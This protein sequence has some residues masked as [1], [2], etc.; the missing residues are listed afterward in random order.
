MRFGSSFSDVRALRQQLQQPAL[1]QQL[2]DDDV[3]AVLQ[4][5]ATCTFLLHNDNSDSAACIR[6]SSFLLSFLFS[7][8]SLPYFR[9]LVTLLL[10]LPL[11]LLPRLL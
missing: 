7:L 3:S 5:H 10:N 9:S 1:R 11:S 6:C 4:P 8:V 2:R